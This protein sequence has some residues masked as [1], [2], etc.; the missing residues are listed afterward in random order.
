MTAFPWHRMANCRDIPT[1]EFYV[2]YP[3]K[4]IV[5]ACADCPVRGACLEWA[6]EHE[7]LGYWAGTTPKQRRAMRREHGIKLETPESSH[8]R[9]AAEC[10]TDSGYYR[11][12]RFLDQPACDKCI[13][14]H[15]DYEA[16]RV[17]RKKA[18]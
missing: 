3:G 13:Q 2:E 17:A 15:R 14:A 1:A 8:I 18:S 9:L 10:G 12:I 16:A 7:A 5:K 4:R 6:V 11:H